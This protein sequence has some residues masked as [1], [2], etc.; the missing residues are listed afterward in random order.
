MIMQGFVR[1]RVPLWVRRTVTILPS[2]V[3]VVCGADI[4]R[5]LI[6]SQV[7]LSVTLPFPM[8][9]IVWFIGQT[10][11]MGNYAVPHVVVALAALAAMLVIG[12]NVWL[13]LGT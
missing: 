2:V 11:I 3:V 13:V 6:A 9:A 1:F 7:V 12:M 4:T 5:A 8:V 10:R